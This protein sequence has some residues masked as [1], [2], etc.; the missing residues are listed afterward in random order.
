VDQ[1][2]RLGGT[3]VELGVQ[4]VYDDVLMDVKRGHSVQDSME[5]TQILKDSG[6]KV[7]YHM[8][9]GLPGVNKERDSEAFIR[10]FNDQAFMPDMLKIYPTLVVKDTGLY[11]R[12]DKGEYKALTDDDAVDLIVDLKINLPPWVRIQRIQ[13]DIPV[14]C[15]EA[16]VQKS[17]LRQLVKRRLDELGKSCNCIRCR[18][19]GHL[20]L[21]GIEP[22]QNNIDQQTIEYQA[23]GGDEVFMS[24][25]DTIN[26]ILIA[27]VRLRLP[28]SGTHRQ[29]F[30]DTSDGPGSSD[31]PKTAI[32]RELKVFGPMVQLDEQNIERDLDKT[33]EWQH[34]GYGQ[35]LL[36]AAEQYAKERWDCKKMLIMSGV[37]VRPYYQ[38]F[39]YGRMGF[40][41][42]KK[43]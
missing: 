36:E 11:K 1:I 40:Y 28:S 12:W 39:G 4:T 8:M 6:F 35:L 3:R 19:V 29:E 30:Y 38:K 17:N 32:I 41:M 42:G 9:P 10:I 15:I 27:F 13:R 14:Q 37:G 22:E 16:G 5:A 18:E 24:Y 20:S 34:R 31:R 25:E 21:L 2:L 26:K 43:L 7:C 23:S 33:K